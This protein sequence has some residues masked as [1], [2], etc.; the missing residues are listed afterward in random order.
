LGVILA[1]NLRS[2][3]DILQTVRE[4]INKEYVEYN[5]LGLP[6]RKYVAAADALDGEPC[7]VIEYAYYLGSTTIKGRMEGISAWNAGFIV[8]QDKL[9]DDLGNDLVDDFGIN[10]AG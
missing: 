8:E 4:G 1:N 6:Q 10:L 2:K 5:P 9:V 3:T 7:L